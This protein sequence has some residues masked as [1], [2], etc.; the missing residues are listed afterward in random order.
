MAHHL[1]AI[2]VDDE[3]V[4]DFL[5]MSLKQFRTADQ[6][7]RRMVTFGWHDDSGAGVYA[8][9]NSKTGEVVCFTPVFV[10]SRLTRLRFLSEYKD[11]ECDFCSGIQVALLDDIE[12][13]FVV[14]IADAVAIR[15]RLPAPGSLLSLSLAFFANEL[16]TYDDEPG[17]HRAQQAEELQMALP[18]L[19]PAGTIDGYSGAVSDIEF[20]GVVLECEEKTNSSTGKTYHRACVQTLGLE[21]EILVEARQEARDFR[22]ELAPG[23]V[24]AGNFWAVGTVRE[25]LLEQKVSPPQKGFLRRLLSRGA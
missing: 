14:Q 25:G 24:V 12:V 23:R 19:L 2:G 9:V 16:S 1:A 5:Q 8:H 7:S 15:E 11:A 3:D 4:N 17:Y 20:S 6:V 22:A 18:F 21:A 10:T 13:P